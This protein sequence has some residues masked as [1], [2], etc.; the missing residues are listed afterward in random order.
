MTDDQLYQMLSEHAD[1]NEAK[2]IALRFLEANNRD[3]DGFKR[4]VDP[5]TM[6]WQKEFTANGNKYRIIDPK[7]GTSLKRY[8][9]MRSMLAVVG[10][11]ATLSDQLRELDQLKSLLDEFVNNKKGIVDLSVHVE[12]MRQSV[13]RANRDWH[14]STWA[15]TYFIL[16][17]GEDAS[18]FDEGVAQSKIEDWNTENIN[19]EDF[20]LCCLMWEQRRNEMLSGF[21]VR[22]V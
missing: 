19:A 14:F 22:L 5:V 12:N 11:N 8:S 1:L 3:A 15:A 16:R 9:Q 18:V 4:I 17:E 10:R 7:D 6:R 20:F 2:Q 21:T 13:A